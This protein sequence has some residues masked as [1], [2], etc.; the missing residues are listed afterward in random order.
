V[1]TT[2]DEVVAASIRREITYLE[3][4]LQEL[5]GETTKSRLI[6]DRIRQVEERVR[7]LRTAMTD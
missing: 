1:T 4:L 2:K 3:G 6:K 5:T 7:K